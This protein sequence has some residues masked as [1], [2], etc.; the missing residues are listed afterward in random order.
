MGVI[1]IVGTFDDAIECPIVGTGKTMTCVYY[2]YMDMINENREIYTNFSTNF[3]HKMRTYD[4]F[5][6]IKNSEISNASIGIDELSTFLNSMGS[7]SQDILFSEK[8]IGQM[9]KRNIDM[10]WTAQRFKSAVNR[11][12]ILTNYILIPHKTHLDFMPC[13]DPNCKEEHFILV[14]SE[15]PFVEKPIVILNAQN[16]GELY[17]TYEFIDDALNMPSERE[18]REIEKELKKMKAKNQ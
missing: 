13:Y 10:Y 3:S 7:K 2:L 9:R 12:R 4:I 14:Y 11:V 5:M 16:V 1:G 18:K 15:N 6:G 17:D 8:I